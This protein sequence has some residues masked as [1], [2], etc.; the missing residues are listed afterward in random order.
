MSWY[1]RETFRFAAFVCAR[2]MPRKK[3]TKDTDREVRAAWKQRI[4]AKVRK[5]QE[6]IPQVIQELMSDLFPAQRK[7]VSDR[8]RIVVGHPGRRAGKTYAV[9][10]R[11]TIDALTNPGETI[12]YVHKTLTSG[13]AK[14]GW[15]TLRQIGQKYKLPLKF[16]TNPMRTVTYPGGG[17]VWFV[18]ADK[19]DQI[20]KLRGDAYP[21]AYIDEAG[22]YRHK[23]LE[24]LVD[25]VI[26]PALV[27]H[28]GPVVL[29]GTPSYVAK[30]PFYD[31]V[32][33]AKRSEESVHHWTMLDNPHIPNAKKEMER[34]LA[35]KLW[36]KN[37]PTF[38]REYLGEWVFEKKG[39]VYQGFDTKRNVFDGTL[40]N[41]AEPNRWRYVLGVD[42]GFRAPSAFCALAYDTVHRKVRILRTY[43]KTRLV[44]TAVAAEI[45]KLKQV[46]DFEKVVV[47]AAHPELIEVIHRRG[48][49]FVEPAKKQEKM[50]YIEILNDELRSGI[51]QVNQHGC[52]S[53]LEQYKTLPLSVNRAETRIIEDNKNFPN[54][55]ADAALYGW[56]AC[57]HFYNELEKVPTRKERI[58]AQEAEWLASLQARNKK[59]KWWKGNRVGGRKPP[60]G[61]FRDEPWWARQ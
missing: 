32:F 55:S 16:R 18:G 47:D 40:E 35:R 53:L 31:A 25:D 26:T 8:A 22:T 23:I 52:E 6:R 14:M 41:Q 28:E 20:E 19:E 38:R 42:Y 59:G 54:H 10:A 57:Q 60:A 33:P 3:V 48:G 4:E 1:L 43:E 27:E 39:L 29:V 7:F 46:W 49:I 15:K 44:H 24:T 30:G 45:E 21:A 12:P 36:D 58:A 2:M 50:A 9:C 37:H 51:V 5:R 61:L 56:R 34:T 13:S 17:T 11:L